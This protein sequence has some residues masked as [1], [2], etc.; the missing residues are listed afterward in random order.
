MV[1]S[2]A[3]ENDK[4]GKAERWKSMMTDQK[5]TYQ[6][7]TF[8]D[9]AN[10]RQRRVSES[11]ETLFHAVLICCTNKRID[12]TDEAIASRFLSFVITR[13]EIDIYEFLDIK[14][15]TDN[16]DSQ[17]KRDF[18]H[19][20]CVKQ[21]LIAMAQI[22]IDMQVI[23]EPSMDA[24]NMITTRMTAY[25]EH[26]GLEPASFTRATQIIARLARVYTILNAVIHVFDAPG[27]MYFN[28]VFKMSM[29]RDLTPYLYCTKQIALFVMTQVGEVYYRPLQ[30]MVMATLLKVFVSVLFVRHN[31]SNTRGKK[32][33]G[34]RVRQ[35]E[36]AR[37][38]RARGH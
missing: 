1:S 28:K 38:V 15:K 12:G 10:G 30:M 21:C 27:S 20:L 19:M 33:G 22:L 14:S 32:D 29:L 8:I 3:A 37:G 23:P 18:I 26:H 7:L 9:Q 4:S 16:I 13:S 31:L 34:F 24:Y 6:V 11:I 5:A 36:D 25:F 17:K 35:R 2:A